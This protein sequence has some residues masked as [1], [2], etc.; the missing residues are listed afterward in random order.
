MRSSDPTV[1]IEEKDLA[2]YSEQANRILLS[3]KW[4]PGGPKP[5][6]QSLGVGRE[7]KVEI[8]KAVH[9]IGGESVVL[10]EG[11]N[12]VLLA[13]WQGLR[14]GLHT[15]ELYAK[16]SGLDALR[17]QNSS[18]LRFTEQQATE[19]RA[20]KETVCC[21]ALVSTASFIVWKLSDF[22]S[23][24]ASHT[25]VLFW[26]IPEYSYLDVSY[27]LQCL[28]F[29]YGAYLD[30]REGVQ[31][32][33]DLIKLTLDY[34][35]AAI[36]EMKLKSGS[37]KHAEPFTANVYQLADTDFCI[38]GF[39]FEIGNARVSIEHNRVEL[40]NI[41]GN[42]D[43]KHKA[44][45]ISER[46]L[47]YDLNAKRNP[48]ADLGGFQNPSM[49]YGESGTG[50]SMI[51][52]AIATLIDDGCKMR[53]IP[54]LFHPLPEAIISTFQGGSAKQMADWINVLRDPT[55]IIY[56][57]IDDAEN[58]L[59]SR[60]RQSA[61]EGERGVIGVFLRN[62]ESAYAINRGNVALQLLTN[63]PDALDNAVLTR[64]KDRFYIG[65]AVTFEDFIDQ[66]YLWWTKYKDIDPNFVAMVDPEG[67]VYLSSQRLMDSLSQTYEEIIEPSEER[68]W[69]VFDHTRKLHKPNEQ[70]FY[71][72][73][74]VELKKEFKFASRD[75]RNIQSA[76]DARLLDFDFPGEWMENPELFY[77]RTYDEK[78]TMLI[79]MMR[80]NM[81]GLSFSDIRLQET[82]RYADNL[83]RILDT[84]RKRRI[85]ETVQEMEIREEA[86]RTYNAK[87]AAQ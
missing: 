54:F 38:R 3:V 73:F 25:H 55:K 19:F 67:Y 31:N 86:V 15:A 29:Y 45:R 4:T 6:A 75:L 20:K 42:H 10:P 7:E 84:S 74:S 8:I 51:S 78:R 79:D 28:T 64:M 12:N 46:V 72:R 81:K 18:N 40:V 39:D 71:A 27:A 77:D 50:K 14:I 53:G 58:N 47:C 83:A 23:E 9:R 57:L 70:A 26:G 37:L 82:I 48:I 41:V 76:V 56:A 69:C 33:L 66:D 63:M 68:V 11:I 2:R 61:S 43:A 13:V 21:V 24:D 87:L 34:F 49:G 30:N 62:T 85:E 17:Q 44:R 60:T 1:L 80:Q 59:G 35:R 36:D 32:E 16:A 52:A 65:G 5:V 22:R